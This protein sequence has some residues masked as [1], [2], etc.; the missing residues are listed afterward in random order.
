M[1]GKSKKNGHWFKA[2]KSQLR[3]IAA[4][5][6]EAVKAG[7]ETAGVKVRKTANNR[8]RPD[9]VVTAEVIDAVMDGVRRAAERLAASGFDFINKRK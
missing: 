1:S 6:S 8:N 7:A 2:V 3:Q 5:Y 9:D 4:L